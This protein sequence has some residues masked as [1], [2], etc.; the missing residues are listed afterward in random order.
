MGG[1]PSTPSANLVSPAGSNMVTRS[2]AK[3]R[4]AAIAILC[5]AIAGWVGTLATLVLTTANPPTVNPL[6]VRS[7]DAIVVVSVS[8]EGRGNFQIVE[9][10]FARDTAAMTAGEIISVRQLPSTV[11]WLVSKQW[12]LAVTR[13][14]G[15]WEVCSGLLAWDRNGPAGPGDLMATDVR[16]VVYPDSEAVR[17]A[18]QRAIKP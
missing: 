11:D 16:P 9:V 18:I 3:W 6:Q 12:I 13:S 2:P 15:M 17:E 10:L 5:L 7:A 8:P 1:A 14:G 4:N